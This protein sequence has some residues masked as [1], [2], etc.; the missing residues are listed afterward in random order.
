MNLQARLNSILSCISTTVTDIQDS[1]PR[2]Q[3]MDDFCCVVS[4]KYYAIMNMQA[5]L[6]SILSCVS[7]IVTDIQDSE[8]RNH[9]MDDFGLV[10]Q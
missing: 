5:R 9:D 3:D 7:M 6:N 2:N 10:S 1:E 4:T 8:P